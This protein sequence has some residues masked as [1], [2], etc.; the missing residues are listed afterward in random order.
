LQRKKQIKKNKFQRNFPNLDKNRVDFAIS[1]AAFIDINEKENLIEEFTK[2][3][4][5]YEKELNCSYQKA[6][7]LV[8]EPSRFGIYLVK[9]GYADMVVGGAG[10][11]PVKFLRPALKVLKDKEIQGE[12]GVFALPDDLMQDCFRKI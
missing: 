10:F 1:E 5:Q 8:K 4:L 3:L 7:E 11:E 12:A 6:K 2:S 9:S